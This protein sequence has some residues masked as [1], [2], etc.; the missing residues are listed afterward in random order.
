MRHEVLYPRTDPEFSVWLKLTSNFCS[1]CLR[2]PS[3]EIASVHYHIFIRREE[4]R[5]KP[6]AA[7]VLGTYYQ[8]SYMPAHILIL[9]FD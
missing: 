3:A 2:L 5:I 9:S 8:L 7:C 1:P 6:K 4:L